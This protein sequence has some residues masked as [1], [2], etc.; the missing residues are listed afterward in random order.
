MTKIGEGIKKCGD[1]RVPCGDLKSKVPASYS[2]VGE[3]VTGFAGTCGDF[4]YTWYAR[5]RAHAHT[6]AHMR[7]GNPLRDS[8]G[9]RNAIQLSKRQ[10]VG[11]R[12]PGIQGPRKDSA[13]TPQGPRK[14]LSRTMEAS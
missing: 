5:A 13:N 8:A 1:L 9:P 3:D 10:R 14:V 2:F 12:G 11:L 4:S 6:C 7:E